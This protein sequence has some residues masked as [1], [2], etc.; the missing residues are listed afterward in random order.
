MI[1]QVN[2]NAAEINRILDL[3]NHSGRYAVQDHL[4]P[5]FDSSSIGQER[6]AFFAPLT[7]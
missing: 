3:G 2:L 1:R 5:Y 4:F 7:H 6:E